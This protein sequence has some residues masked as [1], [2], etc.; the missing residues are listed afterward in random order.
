MGT[1]SS[2]A[3]NAAA[4]SPPM[5]EPPIPATVMF[6][7]SP[8]AGGSVALAAIAQASRSC[9]ASSL[10][11]PSM[12]PGSAARIRST[13]SMT[14]VSIVS[15]AIS[16]SPHHLLARVEQWAQL[17]LKLRLRVDPHERLGARQTNEQPRAV[18]EEELRAV[19]G[20]QL[21]DLRHCVTAELLRRR[22][23]EHRHDA[24]FRDRV[25]GGGEV[26]VAPQVMRRSDHVHELGDELGRLLLRLHHEVE[27]EEIRDDSVALGQVHREAEPAGLLATHHRAGLLHLRSDVLEADR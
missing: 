17:V 14:E 27:E 12:S 9:C 25:G 2:S 20:L 18:V 3:S 23:T 26:Q 5:A 22:L 4:K 21:H 1:F 13:D 6:R 7:T 11:R 16:G 15:G 24:L 8:Y 10:I 19:I